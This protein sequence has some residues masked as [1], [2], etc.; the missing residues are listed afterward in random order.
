[1]HV[2]TC[3]YV[4]RLC[5]PGPDVETQRAPVSFPRAPETAKNGLTSLT[6]LQA[7]QKRYN[8]LHN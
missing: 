3:E 1:M 5:R 8:Y 2:M 4:L 6:Q 7:S